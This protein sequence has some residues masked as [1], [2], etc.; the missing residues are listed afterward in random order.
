MLNLSLVGHNDCVKLDNLP[1]PAVVS[2]YGKQDGWNSAP[3]R[4]QTLASCRILD[5]ADTLSRRLNSCD[6]INAER[7]W[8]GPEFLKWDEKYW[9]PSIFTRLDNDL[10]EQRK[11]GI[12]ASISRSYIIDDLL[13][14]YSNLNN[15]PHHSVLFKIIQGTPRARI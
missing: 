4:N 3:D 2:F 1:L 14:K 10:P 9:P 15:M 5:P 12:A 11:I 8:N 13:N 7:W 6:L